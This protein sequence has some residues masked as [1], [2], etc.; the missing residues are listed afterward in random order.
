M[1]ENPT[2]KDQVHASTFEAVQKILEKEGLTGLYTG[3]RSALFGIGVTN[4]VYYYFYEAVKDIMEKARDGK[5]GPLSTGESMLA[6]MLAGSA[7]VFATNP[8]W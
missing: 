7:T 4:G 3:L 1:S 8:I 5:L 2:D 6:G